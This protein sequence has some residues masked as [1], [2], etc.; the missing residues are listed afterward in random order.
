IAGLIT[1][2]AAALVIVPIALAGAISSTTNPA[3]DNGG[4]GTPVLC[5]N[6]GA[7]AN[8][9]PGA[10]NCNIY[11]A[12]NYVWLSGLPDSASL[13]AG[14]YFFAVLDPGGQRNPND[15]TAG[16]LSDDTD[17]YTNR[18]FTIASDG[19]LTTPG[20]HDTDGY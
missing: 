1:V 3:V 6:G 17:P 15:G 8:V 19:T 20:T 11:T 12:K 9:P 4:T 5:L 14:T 18:I 16:N 10:V 2:A 13:D 7:G